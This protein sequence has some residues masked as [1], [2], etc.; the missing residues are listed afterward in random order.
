MPEEAPEASGE[1]HGWRERAV[2]T[3][4]EAMRAPER[5]IMGRLVECGYDEDHRFAI[6]LSFEEAA[7]N[8]MKHG[9]RM[10]PARFV[11]LR[12]QITPE[13]AEIRV[14][15]EGPG[16]DPCLVPDPTCDENLQRPCGRGIMLI[17]AYMDEVSYS[18][19]GNEIRMVKLNHR[20]AAPGGNRP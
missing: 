18:P 14:A 7:V 2:P 11:R 1:L 6:R 10:D 4:L 19:T 3:S 9:N 8:A 12:Y 13:R 5:E 15:D 20:R 16:F 17:R